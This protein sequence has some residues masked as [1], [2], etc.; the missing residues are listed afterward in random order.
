MPSPQGEHDVRLRKILTGEPKAPQWPDGFAMRTFEPSDAPALH[1][2]LELVF[3][4]G[5]NGPFEDWWPRLA[6]DS[7][8][9]PGLCFLVFAG[10]GRLAGAALSWTSAFV[11]DLAVHPDFRGKG[12]AEALMRQVFATFAG[13]GAVH[14]DLKTS[15]VGNADAVRLYRRLGM[16][17]VD[18]G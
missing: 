2:L 11:K 7:K 18:W 16:T 9:D 14:V 10:D 8:F 13:R 6:G 12:I 17:E 5:M 3:D 1:A 4:D 15:L